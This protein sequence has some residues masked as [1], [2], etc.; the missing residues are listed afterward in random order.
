MW[1]DRNEKYDF[2][3][4]EI[5]T[6]RV[7]CHAL[8]GLRNAE[9][10]LDELGLVF[11]TATG[12][13]KKNPLCEVVKNERAG[14]LSCM[15]ELGLDDEQGKREVGRPSGDPRQIRQVMTWQK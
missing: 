14:F 1:R 7:A 4:A 3:A 5:Q 9:Q 11:T 15:K 12:I 10:Q 8:T 13:V 6:L 2:S